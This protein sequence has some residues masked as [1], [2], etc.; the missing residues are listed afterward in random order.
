[1]GF[2]S[3]ILL[4]IGATALALWSARKLANS[5]VRSKDLDDQMTEFDLDIGM[6]MPCPRCRSTATNAR[7]SFEKRECVACGLKFELTD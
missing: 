1:M 5:G 2:P 4:A 3:V 6:G 7:S